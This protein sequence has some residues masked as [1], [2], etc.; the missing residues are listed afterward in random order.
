MHRRNPYK[1]RGAILRLFDDGFEE[2]VGETENG[3]LKIKTYT[4]LIYPT[5]V[6]RPFVYKIQD[7][8]FDKWHQNGTRR[9]ER[10][11]AASMTII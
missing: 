6:L 7:G 1:R 9:E 8:G 2:V 4:G 11:R 3:R 10:W 5:D